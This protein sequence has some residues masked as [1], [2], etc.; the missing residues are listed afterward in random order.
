MIIEYARLAVSV[1]ILSFYII[2]NTAGHIKQST[3]ID[4]PFMF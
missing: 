3:Y 1:R 2:P 4:N